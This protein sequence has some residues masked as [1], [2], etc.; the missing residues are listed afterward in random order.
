MGGQQSAAEQPGFTPGFDPEGY[1]PSVVEPRRGRAPPPDFFDEPGDPEYAG[2]AP[3]VDIFRHPDRDEWL[4]RKGQMKDVLEGLTDEDIVEVEELVIEEVPEVDP[5]T[6]K[7]FNKS[8]YGQLLRIGAG[9]YGEVVKGKRKSDGKMV[10]IKKISKDDKTLDKIG[11]LPKEYVVMKDLDHPKIAKVYNIEE[12]DDYFYIIMKL[13]QGGSVHDFL[14][15]YEIGLPPF[16]VLHIARQLIDAVGYCHQHNVTHGDIKLDNIFISNSKGLPNIALGDF[17]ICKVGPV[18]QALF[19]HFGTPEYSAP[20]L[21]E[22]VPYL[23]T[24]TDVWAIGVCLYILFTGKYPFVSDDRSVMRDLVINSTPFPDDE[25][26]YDYIS[27]KCRQLI[28]WMLTK[29]P[30]QRPSI[31]AI[32]AHPCYTAKYDKPIPGK[33][34]K[35]MGPSIEI[36][37]IYYDDDDLKW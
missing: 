10:A 15:K 27:E 33:K 13:Y 21:F 18:D 29:D 26:Y 36:D 30:N 1:K 20:E 24:K 34:E 11:I 8:N 12:D 23:G 4:F 32:Q 37:T 17:G 3:P 9:T 16:M 28:K 5:M 25:Q 7:E 2:R 22:G 14:D 19:T 31:P 6:P 35:S